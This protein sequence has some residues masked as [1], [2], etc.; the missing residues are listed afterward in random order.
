M[1]LI[2]DFSHFV[3]N[4]NELYI[5]TKTVVIG[6]LEYISMIDL[7]KVVTKWILRSLFPYSTPID[8]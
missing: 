1:L 7:Y 3:F 4:S 2:L 6:A 5:K 8:E